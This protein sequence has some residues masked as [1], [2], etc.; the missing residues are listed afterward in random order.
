MVQALSLAKPLFLRTPG[1]SFKQRPAQNL[2]FVRWTSSLQASH[3]VV[4]LP[5]I[6]SFIRPKL[7]LGRTRYVV[8]TT[9]A[10]R[11]QRAAVV[12]S[13]CVRIGASPALGIGSFGRPVSLPQPFGTL[14]FHLVLRA[15]ISDSG[16]RE[17]PGL[18]GEPTSE[19]NRRPKPIPP[20]PNNSR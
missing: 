8:Q 7:I 4:P 5:G 3:S 20:E 12:E 10:S 17:S 6:H 13:T 15:A 14:T 19:D 1:L 11:Q 2:L 18:G 16:S 9:S